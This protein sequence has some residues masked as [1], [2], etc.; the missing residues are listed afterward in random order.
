[1]IVD[2]FTHMAPSVYLDSLAAMP[3]GGV[4]K[5]L[6]SIRQTTQGRPYTTDPI[7]RVDLL[8]KYSIDY[9]VVTLIHN[10]D[11]N[12]LPFDKETQLAMARVAN[13]GLAGIM[14]Q[15]KGKLL[16]I[17][18]VPLASIQ[19]EGLKEMERA[20][21]SLG[22][23]GFQITSN[24]RG[25]PIDAPEFAWFWEKAAELEVPVF[26]HPTNPINEDSRPY[27]ADYKMTS[28]FGW[29]FETVLM[30]SRLVF[31][32][33]MDRHPNLKVVSHHLGGGMVPFL[34]G[35]IE[36]SYAVERQQAVFGRILARPL[37]E[38]FG[39][40]YYD[41]AV[42]E[43]GPAIKCCCDTFGADRLLL[44]TD[45]PYG[46]GG[47]ARLETYPRAVRESG[48]SARDIEKIMSGNARGLLGI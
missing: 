31:S 40:F 15:S 22:L 12:A 14:E 3:D 45:F 43:H 30:L 11:C 19:D 35:R 9:Q 26:L 5:A 7:R 1:M 33:I 38:Y 32:G 13:D 48:I 28:V 25:K 46:A 36:E 20:I 18:C 17:A 34:W 27:E 4:K 41:T 37:K 24:I 29:P 6:D 2:S 10:I 42:G 44:S 8:K 39:R 23:K 47:E 16:G 21:R